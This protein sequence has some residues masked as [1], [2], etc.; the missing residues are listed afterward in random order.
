MKKHFLTGLVIL[1]PVTLTVLV[2][3]FLFNLLTQPFAG[4]AQALFERYRLFGEGFLFLSATQLQ[5]FIGQLLILALL[6]LGTLLIG[7]AA[8]LFFVNYFIELWHRLIARIPLVSTIYRACSD[9]IGTIFTSNTSAFKQVVLVPF[10][11]ANTFTVGLVTRESIPEFEEALGP[12]LVAVFVPTTPNPTSGF[13]TI[14]RRSQIEFLNM[15]VEDAFKYIISCG[16]V[17]PN[18]RKEV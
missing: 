12:N 11:H 17:I 6:I 14:Y 5:T 7:W 18:F 9:V 15:K 2:I 13:L 4:I 1:L 3:S 8:R 10:P 16:V